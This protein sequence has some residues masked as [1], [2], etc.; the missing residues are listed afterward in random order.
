MDDL[1]E[2]KGQQLEQ[3][4]VK[5]TYNKIAQDFSTTR[6]KK[7][8][9]VDAFLQSLVESSCSLLLDV[10]CGNGKYLD[11]KGTFNIGCDLSLNLLLI[12]KT[13]GFEVVLCDMS[14]LPFRAEVFD[15]V[16]CIAALHHLTTS[17]RRQK[18][19]SEMTKLMSPLGS[20]CLVQVWSFEQQLEK[21]NPYLKKTSES[22]ANEQTNG[23]EVSEHIRLPIHKNRTPFIEQ[24]V[25]VPFH[26]K[27]SEK[28]LSST[29]KGDEE[30]N[31]QQLRYYHVFKE[32]ELDGLFREISDISIEQSY[33]DRGNWCVVAAKRK[34][35]TFR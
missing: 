22:T 23:V 35:T 31:N 34:A 30:K 16:I 29:S 15:S 4:Y 27:S 11:N 25:L 6:Y 9:K 24:D 20:Q 28:T 1:P 13:R 3:D 19:L 10:G 32:G 26:T 12:C 21:D 18:C 17:R 2:E 7:W 14:R 5:S 33:Y 8:P